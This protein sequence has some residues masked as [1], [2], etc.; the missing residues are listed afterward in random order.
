MAATNR[1]R[2]GWRIYLGV[3]VLLALGAA[4]LRRVPL[5]MALFLLAWSVLLGWPVSR[6]VS[7]NLPR[8]L[9]W[10]LA[11]VVGYHALFGP[12]MLLHVL[13]HR[14]TRNDDLALRA[15]PHVIHW[16]NRFE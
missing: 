4:F 15:W 14:A 12:A 9:V 3:V 16:I 2:R 1:G 13:T 7:S 10:L 6:L 8:P 5:P 11:A